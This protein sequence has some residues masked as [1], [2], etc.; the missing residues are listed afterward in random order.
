MP[1]DIEPI[2]AYRDGYFELAG[3]GFSGYRD[4]IPL[5][6]LGLDTGSAEVRD[7]D[8]PNP[9]GDGVLFGRDTLGGPTWAFDINTDAPDATSALA[10]ASRLATAWRSGRDQT[11]VALPL[12][13]HTGGRVRRVYGRP[14]RYSGPTPDLMT[15]KG[16]ARITADFQCVDHLHYD[17]AQR[18]V[19]VRL[20]TDTSGGWVLPD[21]WPIDTLAGGQRQGV[22]DDVGGDA[23][24]PFRLQFTGPISAPWAAGPGWRVELPDLTLAYDQYVTVLTHPWALT[25]TRN[26]GANLAG[27]LSPRT[28]LLQARM[29]P[30]KGE[31]T[32]GGIDP[33]NTATCT[34]SWRPAWHGL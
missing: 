16:K 28:R 8:K 11:G 5:G 14:R 23:T 15:N 34:L 26:D 25:V 19:T 9:V 31:F 32:F 27:A 33:T 3:V 22:I 4:E 7:Q 1:I 10:H 12:T 18:S 13:Y 6:V 24:T 21:Q 2:E 17:E 30:G 20:V 29:R